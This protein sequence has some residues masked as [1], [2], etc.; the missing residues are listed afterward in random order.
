MKFISHVETSNTKENNTTTPKSESKMQKFIY[1]VGVALAICCGASSGVLAQCAGTILSSQNC[2][3]P[4]TQ[5][6]NNENLNSGVTRWNTGTNT[7]S[8]VNF[9]GGTLVVC[10]NLTLSFGSVN[11][12]N[13]IVQPNSTLT[14]SSAVS[15]NNSFNITN[16]GVVSFNG[17]VTLQNTGNTL[18]NATSNA[19]MNFNGNNLT[20][21]GS[22]S[23]II[24]NGSIGAVNT[25]ST[26]NGNGTICM[27][28]NA[29]I[30]VA[31]ITNSGNTHTLFSLGAG[32]TSACV[33]ITGTYAQGHAGA[34]NH[35]PLSASSGLKLCIPGS[36]ASSVL[37]TN[38][39]AADIVA[40]VNTN[41][42]SCLSIQ[43]LPLQLLSFSAQAS[44]NG[45]TLSF[46]TANEK[47]IASFEVERSADGRSFTKIGSRIIPMNTAAE[48]VY[49]W[50]DEQPVA[51]MNYY[52]IKIAEMDGSSSYSGTVT[53]N[54]SLRDHA[55]TSIF[56]NPAQDKINIRIEAAQAGAD[57]SV[58]VEDMTGRQLYRSAGSNAAEVN[59]SGWQPG[60]YV[61]RT[62][63]NGETSVSRFVKS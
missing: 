25:I 2:A 43:P 35:N 3:S 13:I 39:L 20:L 17:D 58:S 27:G 46:V 55:G 54:N 31:N 30:G 7:I 44:G 57:I 1:S 6:S 28:Q 56:P 4:G 26:A 10:G 48:H 40:T 24:N 33:R 34:G 16:Y 12:G 15:F 50:N 11:S 47:S 37:G 32:V 59:I 60:I 9:N 41:C 38:T 36:S 14:V 8:G 29:T 19:S 21:N 52:R 23:A 63:I 62:T 61:V 51:G 49:Y 53:V 42:I 5:V 45:N 18:A 22:S